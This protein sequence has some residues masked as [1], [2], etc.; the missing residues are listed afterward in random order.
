MHP[1]S[2]GLGLIQNLGVMFK[3]FAVHQPVE[4]DAAFHSQ[5]SQSSVQFRRGADHKLAGILLQRKR[6]RDFFS[7]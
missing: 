6:L 5:R 7:G 1:A 2:R 3:E 4:A